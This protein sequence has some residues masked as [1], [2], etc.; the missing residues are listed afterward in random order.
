M[1]NNNSNSIT[2]IDKKTNFTYSIKCNDQET[3]TRLINQ[4]KIPTPT[5]TEKKMH[6]I[7]CNPVK[8]NFKSKSIIGKGTDNTVHVLLNK[9]N[10][11]NMVLRISKVYD[12]DTSSTDEMEDL[13]DDEL[14]GY[15]VQTHLSKL[16]SMGGKGCE[17]ICKVYQFGT[18]YEN[19]KAYAI[20]EKLVDFGKFMVYCMKHNDGVFN[21]ITLFKTHTNFFKVIIDILINVLNGLTCIHKY[22]CGHFDIKVDNIGLNN[23]NEHIEEDEDEEEEEDEDEDEEEEENRIYI[24]K[25]RHKHI[26]AKLMDFG[27]MKYIK[28]KDIKSPYI[29]DDMEQLFTHY[30]PEAWHHKKLTIK[31][32][33]YM[34]GDMLSRLYFVH[35]L[36]IP[37]FNRNKILKTEIINIIN[38]C[39]YPT[40]IKEEDGEYKRVHHQINSEWAS[41]YQEIQKR[42][43]IPELINALT[44]LKNKIIHNNNTKHGGTKRRSR[45]KTIKKRNQKKKSR[46]KV[47]TFG[48]KSV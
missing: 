46:R 28:E 4:E 8:L 47:R 35:I 19:Q 15:F 7:I 5:P 32:D 12:N 13:R 24:V 2:D 14:S 31:S 42:K 45:R 6:K 30:P 22:K 26:V 48:R 20:L 16:N 10:N 1:K 37:E 44:K 18:F 41:Y 3:I 33:I 17:N 11:T 34:F 29:L 43:S 39:M 27:H 40:E 25:N 9:T 36:K 21:Y 38:V 23:I